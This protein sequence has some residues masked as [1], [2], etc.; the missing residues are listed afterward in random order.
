MMPTIAPPRALRQSANE[1]GE[2]MHAKSSNRWLG[3]LLL[4]SIGAMVPAAWAASTP[5]SACGIITTSG[6]YTVTK[7]LTGPPITTRVS[8]VVP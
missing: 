6:N 8:L 5:I 1:K 7:D 4:F 2:I 3:L